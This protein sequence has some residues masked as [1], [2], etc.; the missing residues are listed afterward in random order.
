MR[1]V[2]MLASALLVLAACGSSSSDTEAASGDTVTSPIAEFLGEDFVFDDSE[3]SRARLIAEERD[4][5]ELIAACMREEGFEYIPVDPEQSFFFEEPGDLEWGS[6]EWVAKY[7]FG[8]TTMWFSQEEVGP[9]LVGHDYA[10][11]EEEQSNDPNQEIVEAMSFSEQD[12]YYAALYGNDDF[13]EFDET[14]SDEEIDAELEDF[15]F[16]PSGCEGQAYNESDH[17]SFKFYEEFGDELEGMYERAQ[18][19]PRVVEAE[20]EIASCVADKGYEYTNEQEVYQRFDTELTSIENT[21]TFPGDELTEEDFSTMSE[22]E[23]NAIFNQP[24]ELSDEALETLAEIQAEEVSLAV[25]VN[26]CGGGFANQGNLVQ[27]VM[28]ELE[29]EFLDQNADR[30]AEFKAES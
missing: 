23:L 15:D 21:L 16:R 3:E 27:E 17:P 22:E 30:V 25:A 6:D 13:P 2:S 26:E 24:R 19:D 11:F 12:A 1:A 7:G 18:N 9:N 28:A 10:S 4:R 14:M 5:Q 8:I 29:Q 20:Q